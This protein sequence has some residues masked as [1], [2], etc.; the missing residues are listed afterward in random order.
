M[1][2]STTIADSIRARWAAS[3]VRVE[4]AD[5]ILFDLDGVLTDTATVHEH[6]W[7][8][9]FT[10]FFTE[11]SGSPAP[12]TDADYFAHIDGRP[13][14]D[15]V[16]AVLRSRGIDLPEGRPDDPPDRVTVRGLGNRKNDTFA[17]VLRAEGVRVYPGSLALLDRLADTGVPMAVVSSSR[18]APA[19][20]SAAGLLDRFEL[21]VDGTV[22]AARGLDG[23]PAA[24]TYLHA[25]RILDA[26]PR[27]SVVVEDAII[28]VQA[29]RAGGFWVTGVD[30]GA[31]RE[32]LLAHG[33]D[34]VV[35]DLAEL[36][37]P[38]TDR[39]RGRP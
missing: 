14:Y 12:Y 35:D 16:R 10:E 39:R 24:A 29:G 37:R 36:V 6:A 11:L 9:V 17:E 33:A 4:E 15:G 13:R 18:N 27:C 20:L 5:A 32:H 3:T 28:G 25:A 7:A 30:R 34:N 22:A 21:I 2:P 31:G 8:R 26:S 1:I 19:V 38:V 23:K